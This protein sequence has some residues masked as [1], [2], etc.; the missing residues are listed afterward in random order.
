[1]TD[2]QKETYR[3]VQAHRGTIVDDTED[4]I[5]SEGAHQGP[6]DGLKEIFFRPIP[7]DPDSDS[8]GDCGPDDYIA[9]TA[10][11]HPS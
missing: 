4:S 2:H 1:M 3:Y 5:E 10:E 6:Q 8:C 11:N 9:L 7:P